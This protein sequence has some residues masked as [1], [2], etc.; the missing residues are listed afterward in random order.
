MNHIKYLRWSFFAKIVT[1]SLT[2]THCAGHNTDLPSNNNISKTVRVNSVFAGT[3]FK[4]YSI[5]FLM[6]TTLIDFALA[7]L[8]LLLFKVCGIFGTSKIDFFNFSSTERMN[9]LQPLTIFAKQLHRR[10]CIFDTSLVYSYIEFVNMNAK[11][12]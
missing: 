2:V 9:G 3:I 4:D 10:S 12:R 11:T 1:L 6:I 7:V 8:Q 5:S